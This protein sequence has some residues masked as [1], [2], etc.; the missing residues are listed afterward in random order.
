MHLF[1]WAAVLLYAAAE[2][3]AVRDLF[4]PRGLGG[5]PILVGAGLAAQFT[6]LTITARA[7]GS[8]PY[9]TLGGSMALFGWMLGLAYLVL[10]L[11]H[12]ERAVGPFLIP[13]ILLFSILAV[14]F[15]S[16]AAPA[17]PATRGSVFAFHVTL[18]MLA[19]AAFALSF[20]LSLLYLIQNRQ[21]R[22]GRTGI[23]FAR[24]P[25]LDVIGRMNRTSVTIG[26]LVLSVSIVLGVAWARRVWT[27]PVD[28][29]LAWALVTLL[30]YGILLWMDRRGWAGAR[31]AVLSIVGF[32][33]VLFS[34]T[35][36]NLYLSHSHVFR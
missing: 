33:L 31:V 27:V 9:R 4:R 7:L 36:V 16:H 29:K 32:I 13:F 34:Y 28:A 12:R 5:A 22:R 10:V 23:L 6:D 14:V 30:V 15:P 19:Y 21:I 35:F 25:A 24:L 3:L 8:V 17:G 26:L 2:A 20:V 11:R 1:G 18:A